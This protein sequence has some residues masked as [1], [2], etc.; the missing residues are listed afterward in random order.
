MMVME[1]FCK[2]RDE[3]SVGRR[4]RVVSEEDGVILLGMM[5]FHSCYK[6]ARALGLYSEPFQSVSSHVK[7][8]FT[9]SSLELAHAGRTQALPPEL[10]RQPL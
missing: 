1:V 10:S 5:V 8:P 9:G 6:Q 2:H 3:I 7:P 4:Y